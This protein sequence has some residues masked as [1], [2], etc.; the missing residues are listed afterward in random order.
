M[1]IEKKDLGKAIA[2]VATPEV[3]DAEQAY[4]RL[5]YVKHNG[6]VYLSKQDVPIGSS[7]TGGDND[8]YWLDYEVSASSCRL[9]RAYT[10]NINYPNRPT[11]GSYS[12]HSP[13]EDK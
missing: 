13:V 2:T 9:G 8:E 1:D 12:S 6:R 3:Y 4:E 10:C 11:G 7:P 5:T